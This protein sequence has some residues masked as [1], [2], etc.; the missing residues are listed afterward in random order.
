MPA[1]CRTYQQETAGIDQTSLAVDLPLQPQELL[2]GFLNSTI[3]AQ[4][5][6]SISNNIPGQSLGSGVARRA[7]SD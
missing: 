7:F 2:L 6:A 1:A 4:V 3:D 5:R